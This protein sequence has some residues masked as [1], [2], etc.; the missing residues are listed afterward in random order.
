[1]D[2]FCR[3]GKKE[4]FCGLILKFKTMTLVSSKEFATNED[5]YFDMAINEEVFVQR[6]NIVFIVARADENK[7]KH[8]QADDNLRRAISPM[9]TSDFIP[10]KSAEQII[11][12]LRESRSFGKT[13]IIEPF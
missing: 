3:I 10:E 11:A 1:V 7:K 6:G 8:L 2:F 12:E 4:Y 13:R 9:R 5:T